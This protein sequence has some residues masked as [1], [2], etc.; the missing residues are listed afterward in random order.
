MNITKGRVKTKERYLRPTKDK[1]DKWLEK[2]K[3]YID[4]NDIDVNMYLCG[5]F[6]KDPSTTWDV[7]VIL[8][9]PDAEHFTDKEL[10]KIRDFMEYCM[11]LGFDEFRMCI[12]TCFYFPYDEDGNFWYSAEAY[13]KNGT[14]KTR[15]LFAYDSIVFND[16][17]VPNYREKSQCVKVM[18]HLFMITHDTPTPK[19]IERIEEGIMY[20]EP[21]QI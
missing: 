12:D 16:V 10:T 3:V 17:T 7:D 20:G 14:I 11:Q 18:E 5:G 13:L 6:L 8:S 15:K 1:F 4:N 19:D 21:E 2:V 9:H